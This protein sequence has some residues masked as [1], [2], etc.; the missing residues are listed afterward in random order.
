[1]PPHTTQKATAASGHGAAR[2]TAKRF[3][4]ESAKEPAKEHI[5]GAP[6]AHNTKH[7]FL[8]LSPKQLI[9]DRI[10]G[11]LYRLL[12][13]GLKD[14]ELSKGVQLVSFDRSSF[15]HEEDM[16]AVFVERLHAY[17]NNGSER[18]NPFWHLTVSQILHQQVGMRFI[19]NNRRYY[20]FPTCVFVSTHDSAL[21]D[22]GAGS[23]THGG[24]GSS[25]RSS[26]RS[27]RSRR[28]SRRSENS[29]TV[30]YEKAHHY[31]HNEED[32]DRILEERRRE[33]ARFRRM[34]RHVHF[35][36]FGIHVNDGIGIEAATAKARGGGARATA[37][38]AADLDNATFYRY[39][40]LSQ[41]SESLHTGNP[42]GE[43]TN[44]KLLADTTDVR[45]R[46]E[47]AVTMLR[48]QLEKLLTG[49]S[50]PGKHGY[51]THVAVEVGDPANS[52]FAT[53]IHVKYDA[54]KYVTHYDP[55]T[56]DKRH[57]HGF[58]RQHAKDTRELLDIDAVLKKQFRKDDIVRYLIERG[59][60][61][62]EKRIVLRYYHETYKHHRYIIY[63]FDVYN[64]ASKMA[65]KVV[66]MV[67]KANQPDLGNPRIQI[68]K[69]EDD[70]SE[71]W[72]SPEMDPSY[73][74]G[75]NANAEGPMT[76]DPSRIVPR[77]VTAADDEADSSE[78]TEAGQSPE[79]AAGFAEE[80]EPNPNTD[81]I[82]QQYKNLASASSILQFFALLILDITRQSHGARWSGWFGGS[83]TTSTATQNQQGD[84]IYR[85][86]I[87]TNNFN[88]TRSNTT[89]PFRFNT[90]YLF[91]NLL[92]CASQHVQ[93][94]TYGQE[95]VRKRWFGSQ[96]R[97][98]ILYNIIAGAQSVQGAGSG[99]FHEQPA[100]MGGGGLSTEFL[101]CFIRPNVPQ[102]GF[103]FRSRHF[104]TRQSSTVT[105][106][107]VL[108]NLRYFYRNQLQSLTFHLRDRD[109]PEEFFLHLSRRNF[110]EMYSNRI[111][112][113]HG[114]FY[115]DVVAPQF[116]GPF[117]E[118][119]FY[120]QLK[121]A[122]LPQTTPSTQNTP[123]TSQTGG[124]AP[125]APPT[126]PPGLAHRRIPTYYTDDPEFTDLVM[127]AH[128]SI[129]SLK[130]LR[131]MP[132]RAQYVYTLSLLN[133][134]GSDLN[135]T[136]VLN[137]ATSR[138][139]T[140]TDELL[141]TLKNDD[142]IEMESRLDEMM[143]RYGIQNRMFLIELQRNNT[144]LLFHFLHF[145]ENNG[146]LDTLGNLNVTYGHIHDLHT[147]LTDAL[148]IDAKNTGSFMVR[149]NSFF[150][151]WSFR[152]K[153]Q[154]QEQMA[155]R[156]FSMA[157]YLRIDIRL[158]KLLARNDGFRMML[159][160]W[161]IHQNLFWRIVHF[162]PARSHWFSRASTDIAS[163]SLYVFLPSHLYL[164]REIRNVLPA[165]EQNGRNSMNALVAA[166]EAF[167]DKDVR[168]V[169]NSG[170]GGQMD[171]LIRGLLFGI[172]QDLLQTSETNLFVVHIEKKSSD[173][174]GNT[175]TYWLFAQWH[176]QYVLY[177]LGANVRHNASGLRILRKDPRTVDPATNRIPNLLDERIRESSERMQQVVRSWRNT[178]KANTETRTTV[179]TEMAK[180]RSLSKRRH[181]M[182][183]KAD[184]FQAV[185]GEDALADYQAPTDLTQSVVAKHEKVYDF[186][187]RLQ[188]LALHKQ[189]LKQPGPPTSSKTPLTETAPYQDN[190]MCAVM[191]L[192]FRDL[193][194]FLPS[195]YNHVMMAINDRVRYCEMGLALESGAVL[196][197]G[198]LVPR[199]DPLALTEKGFQ[200][201]VGSD[202][203]MV[204]DESGNRR[205]DDERHYLIRLEGPLHTSGKATINRTL[206]FQMILE[207]LAQLGAVQDASFGQDEMEVADITVMSWAK[208]VADK[209]VMD[210][211][212][213]ESKRTLMF[214]VLLNGIF[215]CNA[216]LN[217]SQW[218]VLRTASSFL[219]PSGLIS[220]AS[221]AVFTLAKW[222]AP[223]MFSFGWST[224]T[225]GFAQGFIANQFVGGFSGLFSKLSE[226]KDT[227]LKGISEGN[228]T[229]AISD[230]FQGAV[231]SATQTAG[232]TASSL[233]NKVR[234]TLAEY[235]VTN[236]RMYRVTTY[237][238]HN[239]NQYE[240]K[241]DL[242]VDKDTQMVLLYHGMPLHEGAAKST[243]TT[244][245]QKVTSYRDIDPNNPQLIRIR[246]HKRSQRK[247][248][249]VLHRKRTRSAS[250]DRRNTHTRRRRRQMERQQRTMRDV[251][252][253]RRQRLR[254][255]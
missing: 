134:F 143:K 12:K 45:K 204:R 203:D 118:N 38:S 193:Y 175:S 14:K 132:T 89:E 162:T 147:L 77:L 207:N 172:K 102:G 250:V 53:T 192:V 254:Y 218:S 97:R 138:D 181:S 174:S 202:A 87:Q 116:Y 60:M 176:R 156:L 183:R 96:V 244:V 144:R 209:E 1:M 80:D 231:S 212:R 28:S 31:R 188:E 135:V 91:I 246:D 157:P 165:L 130:G 219:F 241:F 133:Q 52:T 142:Q 169:Y 39:L 195:Q 105:A 177:D 173:S 249:D 43:L 42:N 213:D 72:L 7:D 145:V 189:L 238:V 121:R 184:R 247:H 59:D 163:F 106:D 62:Q 222:M 223:L 185:H 205:Y 166:Q 58:Y 214:S 41:T 171:A 19:E 158:V 44:T 151:S 67:S 237:F 229:G 251:G 78:Y 17:V 9:G 224:L 57:H 199:K 160:N 198:L 55:E 236:I 20:V 125:G 155:E 37:N 61:A 220:M 208:Y 234:D 186:I 148:R 225:S 69:L 95:T 92:L 109:D 16:D 146:A 25:Q 124:P 40:H 4:N 88:A 81:P 70:T 66:Q 200:Y 8:R 139:K 150:S 191:W 50:K 152:G 178:V 90:S 99:L 197:G 127:D 235:L 180:K 128:R 159:H 221:G 190:A 245:H 153:G 129:L 227:L 243:S 141:E 149:K 167:D 123:Y 75:A 27:R 85:N 179:H 201:Y 13:T 161:S 73:P 187:K 230:L 196:P 117:I 84:G 54:S 36:G 211:F 239:G 24:R 76:Y 210:R 82:V 68:Y 168:K 182:A 23:K 108:Q 217:L 30:A 47:S 100:V 110:W 26:R 104:S 226:A 215:A 154:S 65:G 64:A 32:T 253:A 35:Y 93:C 131:Y 21:L 164:T 11:I 33:T 119:L 6:T 140:P 83:S 113:V 79:G 233:G 46:A 170:R 255:G 216:L 29:D 114:P 63:T 15:I 34:Q 98:G 115:K 71:F 242:G 126:L 122:I 248:Y 22:S 5:G 3:A 120:S 252:A 206:M 10:D 51:T 232:D 56:H 103:R 74:Q 49:G 137:L 18:N 48:G 94:L 107:A 240:W 112:L 86:Q 101:Q 2:M 136:N 111:Q 228:L 194:T